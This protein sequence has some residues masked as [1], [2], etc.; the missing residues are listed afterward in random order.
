MRIQNYFSLTFISFILFASFIHSQEFWEQTNGPLGGIIKTLKINE[1]GMVFAGTDGAGIYRTVNGGTFW[2][3][4]NNGV[5]DHI[6]STIAMNSRGH[7]FI[8]SNKG[9]IYKSRK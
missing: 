8:G 6:I 3:E 2:Q 7:I 4:I 5:N 1:S 9:S